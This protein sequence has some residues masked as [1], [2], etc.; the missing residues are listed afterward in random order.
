MEAETSEDVIDGG[1]KSWGGGEKL[2]KG[3]G[4]KREGEW[5]LRKPRAL[6]GWI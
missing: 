3:E 2:A 5:V 1:A 6:L 4:E